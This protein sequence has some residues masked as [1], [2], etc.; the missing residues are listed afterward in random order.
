MLPQRDVVQQEG[1]LFEALNNILSCY[2]TFAVIYF[3]KMFDG[4]FVSKVT[5]SLKIVELE[6]KCIKIQKII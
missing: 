4:D 5:Q 1:C 2:S 6:Q 3:N